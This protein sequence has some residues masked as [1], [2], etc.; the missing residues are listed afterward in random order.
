MLDILNK[1]E[2]SIDISDVHMTQIKEYLAI[3]DLIKE[4]DLEY[5][6]EVNQKSKIVVVT[7]PGLRYAQAEAIVENLLLDEKFQEL[8]IQKRTHIL[9]RLLSEIRGRMMEDIVLLETK[10]AKK[11]KHVFK[12]QFPIGEFDM[13]VQDPKTLSCEIYEIKYSKVRA[14][15]QYRHISN[16][17]KCAMTTHRY[18]NITG[19]Y[20]I[21]RGENTEM[22]TIQYLNVE[23]YL[24]SL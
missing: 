10:L 22:D 9:E 13:V 15:E 12:L 19:R 21:Y 6:P 5:L 2:Q 7:Q 16:E 11:D 17:E 20:V 23:D 8:D 14:C 1:E 3:L 4:I 18:G 24:K